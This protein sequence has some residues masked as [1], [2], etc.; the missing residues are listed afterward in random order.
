MILCYRRV[1]VE[2]EEVWVWSDMVRVC[3][4]ICALAPADSL[5]HKDAKSVKP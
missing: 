2:A 3:K 5:T 1:Q 4:A